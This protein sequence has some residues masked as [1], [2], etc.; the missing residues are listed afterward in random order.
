MEATHTPE[1]WI[2]AAGVTG[3]DKDYNYILSERNGTIIAKLPNYLGPENGKRIVSCI[4]ALAGIP[5][6][7]AW[8]EQAKIAID[9]QNKG[10]GYQNE[11]M[12]AIWKA[13]DGINAFQMQRFFNALSAYSHAASEIKILQKGN[14]P[15][16]QATRMQTAFDRLNAAEIEM[17]GLLNIYRP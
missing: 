11:R 7:A 17:L 5:S 12:G 13:A 6:P 8:V 2:T 10:V 3:Q 14:S 15:I 4:N 9:A 1:N 16:G